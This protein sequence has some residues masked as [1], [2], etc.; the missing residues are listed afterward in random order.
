[1]HNI[2]M[3]FEDLFWQIVAS[4]FLEN[5]V[6]LSSFNFSLFVTSTIFEGCFALVALPKFYVIDLC[7]ATRGAIS[8]TS[9]KLFSLNKMFYSEYSRFILGH[10]KAL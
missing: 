5:N 7:Y 3:I 4:K 1:M 6:Y 9:L 8:Q 2:L 10:C